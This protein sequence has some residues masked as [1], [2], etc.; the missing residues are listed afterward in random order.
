MIIRKKTNNKKLGEVLIERGLITDDQLQ[1]A[2]TDQKTQGGL[3]GQILV[4]KKFI[5][6][7]SITCAIAV[8]YGI[9]YF[10]VRNYDFHPEVV[11][12]VPKDVCVKFGLIVVDRIGSIVTLAM[13][14]PLDN[15]AVKHIE[16]ITKSTARTFIS[17][18]TEIME[19]IEK[20][21]K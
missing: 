2:L 18:V 11:R 8:Q 4:K 7:E 19:A 16:D 3:L 10:P 5:T 12:L 13:T 6:E 20:H 15:D 21:Y 17:T 9:P 14:N 1:E